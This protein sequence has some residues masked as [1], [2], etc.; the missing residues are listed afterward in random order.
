MKLAKQLPVWP[1]WKSVN[2]LGALGLAQIVGESGDLSNYAN[3]GKLW[4]RLGL[5][6]IDGKSQR[7]VSGAAALEH[8]YSPRRRSVMYCIGDSAI[9]KQ[10]PYRDLYLERKEYE[11]AKVPDLTPMHHH[12]RAQRYMEKRIL[13][14]LWQRW[15]WPIAG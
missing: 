3:P 9:K 15:R 11:K 10:S 12:R 5:A 14:H 7:R 1:W 6:V 8:G 4:K 13:K 2:G